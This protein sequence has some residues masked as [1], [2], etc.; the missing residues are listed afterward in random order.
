MQW[1]TPWDV[2]V[3]PICWWPDKPSSVG[4]A[5]L[6]PLGHVKACNLPLF[7]RNHAQLRGGSVAEILMSMLAYG[8]VERCSDVAG[9]GVS[10]SS[11][12]K[13]S[14]LFHLC[15]YIYCFMNYDEHVECWNVMFASAEC[16]VTMH[17]CM[18]D[19][20]SWY[21]LCLSFY[22]SIDVCSCSWGCLPICLVL[23][24]S[25]SPVGGS[26]TLHV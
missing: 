1:L 6:C 5:V 10:S 22:F 9:C 3:W 14:W 24:A 25:S 20:V 21:V 7:Q 26:G 18:M 19:Y 12:D 11:K 13:Y 2:L 17:L 23:V 16:W 15:N 4:L 8:W